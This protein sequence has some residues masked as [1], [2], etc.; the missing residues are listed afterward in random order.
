MGT[1]SRELERY[2]QSNELWGGVFCRDEVGRKHTGNKFFILNLDESTNQGTH[3]ILFCDFLPTG[4][5]Y[6]DPFG[7]PPP[8]EY[9]KFMLRSPTLKKNPQAR[10]LYSKVQYQG[11]TSDACGEFCI[12]LAD[13]LLEHRD[14]RLMDHELTQGESEHNERLVRKVKVRSS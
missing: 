4:P 14:K 5:L 11:I 9:E 13:E 6:V 10:C 7:M 3:W 8:P 1:S 12:E 2:Y